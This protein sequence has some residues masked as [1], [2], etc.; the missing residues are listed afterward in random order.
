MYTQ[1]IIGAE[2]FFSPLWTALT[3]FHT[4]AFK[5]SICDFMETFLMNG[6]AFEVEYTHSVENISNTWHGEEQENSEK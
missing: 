1:C 6:A 5:E 4:G 3:F 2:D